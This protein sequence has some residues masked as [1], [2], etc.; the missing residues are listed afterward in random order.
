MSISTKAL[1]YFISTLPHI[2][3]NIELTGDQVQELQRCRKIWHWTGRCFK[4]HFSGQHNPFDV[5]EVQLNP[6]LED[7]ILMHAD[8]YIKL[9]SLIFV[10]FKVIKSE[11]LKTGNE[12]P[13]RNAQDL[14]KYI[15]TYDASSSIEAMFQ[16][17]KEVSASRLRKSVEHF[18]NGVTDPPPGSQAAS[19]M[20][21]GLSALKRNRE[22]GWCHWDEYIVLL[23][24]RSALEKPQCPHRGAIQQAFNACTLTNETFIDQIP[25]AL[26][27]RGK[28]AQ[29][30]SGS[31]AWKN[32]EKLPSQKGGIY[33]K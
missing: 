21:D 11:A 22:Q 5:G 23:L 33:R 30:C 31:Y 2:S 18:Q 25:T 28:W 16:P 14:F 27:R 12:F 6:K 17:Y 24:V 13:F 1:G 4:A 19:D 10:G 9:W 15:V 32:G 20:R 26:R 29:V 3:S 8:S 7:F